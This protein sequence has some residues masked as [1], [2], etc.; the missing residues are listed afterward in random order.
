MKKF[1][2]RNP[3]VTKRDKEIGYS[4]IET[5]KQLAEAADTCLKKNDGVGA[6]E[7]IVASAR[8]WNLAAK[9]LGFRNIVDM[10]RYFE[11]HG[12]F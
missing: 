12:K 3:F 7:L 4:F 5:A 9:R 2:F 6:T 11:R 10:E 8:H 1:I